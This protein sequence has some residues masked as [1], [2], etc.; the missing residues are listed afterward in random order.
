MPHFYTSPLS[1]SIQ[2]LHCSLTSLGHTGPQAK[3]FDPDT[4][5]ASNLGRQL[6]TEAEIGQNK[7]IILVN[8][9]NTVFG[10]DWEGQCD[11]P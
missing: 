11:I 6:F 10:L 9:L 7:A 1:E 2:Q 5:S 8:R 3:A 4:V